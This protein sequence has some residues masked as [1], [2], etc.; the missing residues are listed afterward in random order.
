MDELQ[1]DALERTISAG[2]R[3]GALKLDEDAALLALCRILADQMDNEAADNDEGPSTRLSAA[4]LS[5]LKDLQRALGREKEKSQKGSKLAHLRAVHSV[6]D[7][8]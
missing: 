4:Y 6:K 7:A 3:R 2:V 1:R 8:G 5:A